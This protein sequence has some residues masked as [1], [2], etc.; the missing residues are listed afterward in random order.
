MV[1]ATME[2]S[3]AA[4]ESQLLLVIVYSLP[5]FHLLTVSCFSTDYLN[6]IKVLLL[7]IADQ[8]GHSCSLL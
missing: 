7:P 3:L 8:E 2:F 4:T 5:D 1:A 6:I